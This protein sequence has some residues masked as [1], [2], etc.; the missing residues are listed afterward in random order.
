MTDWW[1]P[2][3]GGFYQ[4]L[5]KAKLPS[6]GIDLASLKKADA[7]RIAAAALAGSGWLPEALRMRT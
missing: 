2:T 7:A 5:P 4:R 6:P 1:T 3:V